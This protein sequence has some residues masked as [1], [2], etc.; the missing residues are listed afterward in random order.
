MIT[1]HQQGK[2]D[3]LTL[4]QQVANAG[5]AKWVVDTRAMVCCFYDQFGKAMVTEPIPDY[6]Y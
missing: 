4:C 1:E 3:F 2:S 6:G 5:V